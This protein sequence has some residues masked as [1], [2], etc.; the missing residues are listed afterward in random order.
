LQQTP[1]ALHRSYPSYATLGTR[2]IIAVGA[3]SS[4]CEGVSDKLYDR[5]LCPCGPQICEEWVVG[6]GMYVS[7][8][9]PPSFSGAVFPSMSQTRTASRSDTPS[10]SQT[11]TP[12]QSN[13][14]TASQSGSPS[15]TQSPT[16]SQTP[17]PAPLVWVLSDDAQSCDDRCAMEGGCL[18]VS[19]APGTASAAAAVAASLSL[20][21]AEVGCFNGWVT[22]AGGV[23]PAS[24][25]A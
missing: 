16:P 22:S 11:P 5:R 17:S 7:V 8:T 25:T 15:Q 19:F 20:A 18:D 12:S 10:V 3:E 13:S 2:T 6:G 21:D 9:P 24:P 23:C 1:L 4:T 14:A